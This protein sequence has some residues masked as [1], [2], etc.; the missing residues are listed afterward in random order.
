MR[1]AWTWKNWTNTTQMENE[2][3]WETDE[4]LKTGN[5]KQKDDTS[6][7]LFIWW[8]LQF[9]YAVQFRFELSLFASSVFLFCSWIGK[10]LTSRKHRNSC[11]F[12]MRAIFALVV[13]FVLFQETFCRKIDGIFNVV[14]W[15]FW[16]LFEKRCRCLQISR[17]NLAP[18]TTT[19]TEFQA[20]NNSRS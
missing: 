2:Q 3:Q 20:H 12:V 13:R 11:D 10:Q 14:T 6:E 18:I 16:F 19:T 1:K 17:D 5:K 7:F 4:T 8:S 15:L 9:S